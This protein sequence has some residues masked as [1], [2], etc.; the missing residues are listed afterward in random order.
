MDSKKLPWLFLFFF[1]LHGLQAET[2]LLISMANSGALLTGI[3]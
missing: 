3:T 2:M 1:E